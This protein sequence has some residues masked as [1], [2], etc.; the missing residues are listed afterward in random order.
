MASTTI[1]ERQITK[2]RREHL[3]SGE[4]ADYKPGATVWDDGQAKR[5]HRVSFRGREAQ[6]PRD[7]LYAAFLRE[8][9]EDNTSDIREFVPCD[10]TETRELARALKIRHP[11]N[12]DGSDKVL[13]TELLVTKR[14]GPRQ[15]IEAGSVRL[16]GEHG[17]QRQLGSQPE[18]R[19]IEQFWKERGVPWRLHLN[20]GLNTNWARNL[21]FLYAIALRP[22]RA[23]DGADDP[24]VQRAVIRA[25][26]RGMHTPARTACA[27]AMSDLGLPARY[28]L[29]A[30]HLLLAAKHI[31]F[32]V[33]C[34]DVDREPV[35]A[36]AIT[37]PQPVQ[38]I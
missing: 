38:L 2:I 37:N 9:Y 10:Y 31:R 15:W 21:D 4:G 18:L 26:S 1:H 20:D 28:G 5:V 13:K 27:I 16:Q 22:V 24:V 36:L 12:I 30:F 7:C 32:D 14:E 23:G 6:L 33:D 34:L 25:L 11:R 19:I 35:S 29:N 8:C 3:G 17:E